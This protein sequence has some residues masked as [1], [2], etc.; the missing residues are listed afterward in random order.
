MK[1]SIRSKHSVM[2]IVLAAGLIGATGFV[3]SPVSAQAPVLLEGH[4][5]APDELRVG[6]S[7][8]Q[9]NTTLSSFYQ[10][11]EYMIGRVAVGLV[12][13]ES[14]GSLDPD[15]TTWTTS[16]Q[17][18]VISKVQAGLD[19]W[20]A[21]Q[22]EAHLSFVIDQR[23][24]LTVTTG[25][26]PINRAQTSEGLWISDV[27]GRLGYTATSYLS[28][29]RAYVNELRSQYDTD[30]AFTIFVV[31]SSGDP[32]GAFSDGY[33]AYAYVGGPFLVMTYDN[34]GYGP[35]YMDAITAHEVGHIFRALDQYSSANI[36]CTTASGYLGIE[37]QNSQRPDCTSDLP[38][39]MRGGI[40]PYLS[41][42]IDPLAAG[43]IGWRDSDADGILD[44]IDTTPTLTLTT[45]LQSGNLWTYTGQAFD[46]PYPSSTRPA[47]SINTVSIGYQLD[48][49][50]WLS[51]PALK[52]NDVNNSLA[53]TLALTN[54]STGNHRLDV[55]ALNSVGNA[56]TL[57]TQMLI[58][59]D[60]VDG[61][62]DTWLTTTTAGTLGCCSNP[63]ISGEAT[64]YL[65]NGAP[66][67]HIV[68][69]EVQIDDGEWQTAQAADGAFD[70][71]AEDFTL[72]ARLTPGLH[73]IKARAADASGKVEQR[74]AQLTLTIAD[75]HFV[76]L[77]LTTR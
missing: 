26:E 54:L 32:D 77:P 52:T 4:F 65:T 42:A 2:L 61:G 14:D 16:Q 55:R 37:N 72:A 1:H 17:Q 8:T 36:P 31:N 41:Q 23:S 28:R 39:I 60:P 15:Q 74:P 21:R 12:L 9:L 56:S 29:V 71:A 76:Y 25:Y 67:P 53:F 47:L 43:Q 70:S 50:D 34:G 20:A 51:V 69:V 24:T 68:D 45:S 40:S 6:S 62:L 38:S 30:W 66:G 22:P 58:V 64:S 73:M 49:G 11:S 7:A 48:R 75:Q 63:M 59:P 19:W 44:P 18:N 46:Q 10:T 35:D 27:M 5:Q 57:A 13:V 33:F 3:F